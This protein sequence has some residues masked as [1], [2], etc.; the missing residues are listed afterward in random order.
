MLFKIIIETNL[1]QL[2]HKYNLLIFIL[3]IVKNYRKPLTISCF[4]LLKNSD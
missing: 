4:K 2:I 3:N 1:Q